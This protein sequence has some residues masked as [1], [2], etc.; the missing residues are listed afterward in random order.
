MSDLILSL[1][2]KCGTTWVQMIVYR[3]QYDLE[4]PTRKKQLWMIRDY[5]LGK[6][7]AEL[8]EKPRFLKM[9]LRFDLVPYSRQAKYIY[10]V[11]NPF[12]CCVSLH[13][14]TKG[15]RDLEFDLSFDRF[16]YDFLYGK[17]RSWPK[18]ILMCC[19]GV[20]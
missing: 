15:I 2:P 5:F 1:F 8:M 9:H 16:F 17:V 19:H 4:P 20:P 13:R 11:R 18:C 7:G 12:D 14:H 3:M 10:V 6:E